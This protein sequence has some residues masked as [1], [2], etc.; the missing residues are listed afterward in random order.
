VKVFGDFVS[1]Q[2][3]FRR[4]REGISGSLGEKGKQGEN[5]MQQAALFAND[6][7]HIF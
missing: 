7:C 2:K 5:D 6:Y 3:S 4:P 1:R